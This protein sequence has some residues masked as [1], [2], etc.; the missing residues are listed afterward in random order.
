MKSR[1][2]YRIATAIS[3]GRVVAVGAHERLLDATAFTILD[4]SG[5]G[6]LARV[7]NSTRL[8]EDLRLRFAFALDGEPVEVEVSV[9]WI[10]PLGGSEFVEIGCRFEEM[11]TQLQIAVLDHIRRNQIRAVS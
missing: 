4:L 9:S 2:Y 10:R 11:T 1:R 3:P 6:L 8:A 5:G 7:G